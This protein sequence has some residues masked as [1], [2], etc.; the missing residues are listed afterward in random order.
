MA[1]LR[2]PVAVL[3]VVAAVTL[4]TVP[5][6]AQ[7]ALAVS[8]SCED[9][10]LSV[11]WQ[12]A[13]Q[14][15]AQIEVWHGDPPYSSANRDHH[16][17]VTIVQGNVIGVRRFTVPLGTSGYARMSVLAGPDLSQAGAEFEC[18]ISDAAQALV[19]G[20]ILTELETIHSRL[21]N[22]NRNVQRTTTNV[23]DVELL[24]ADTNE[25]LATANDT[26]AAVRAA[27]TDRAHGL[28]ALL[29]S[30]DARL[31]AVSASSDAAAAL[32]AR[33]AERVAGI[34]TV[35]NQ[36]RHQTQALLALVAI[37]FA[38]WLRPVFRSR[39]ATT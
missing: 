25:A 17:P 3:S 31:A 27:L 5:A 36:S 38:L 15:S 9:T 24:L 23:A 35:A 11:D 19:L 18:T 32:Q 16:A 6:G 28:P 14:G 34:E 21:T 37:M 13:P 39:K 2:V 26:L 10:T 22:V 7:T 30:L 4:P 33:T 20:D 12:D 8:V 29:G 1:R